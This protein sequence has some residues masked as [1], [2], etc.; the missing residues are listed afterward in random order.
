MESL[1]KIEHATLSFGGLKAVN[2]VSLEHHG[3][4]IL[5]LI[6]PNGAGK[7]TLFN[8]LTGM[9]TLDEGSVHF[10][11]KDITTKK[12]YER[13]RCGI[14]RTFQ[15]IRLYSQLTVLENLLLAHPACNGETL[16]SCIIKGRKL[17]ESRRRVV[18]ECEEILS[19][20]G[21]L[22][23]AEQL[24]TSLP[25]GKQR[26]LEIGR[27][28]ATDPTLLLLDEPGAGM[29]STEK[30]ELEALIQNISQLRKKHVL[31]IE[32]D[33]KFVM[34][35]SDRIIVLDYGK[36][37]AEGKPAEIQNNQRVVD[38]YLGK[39]RFNAKGEL[40]LGIDRECGV[41]AAAEGGGSLA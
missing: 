27:A 41:M 12:P 1:L 28:L 35:I 30:G 23:Q 7:T 13:V 17:R 9:Y 11:G 39:P 22:E 21:L 26:L 31:L 20:I 6:G 16:L 19:E 8:I 38:A 40:D 14:A 2:D 10:M 5:A 29:N 37:I 3:D 25:Y 33:M 36:K 18:Q 24:A 32:H 34:N 4:E 15:N